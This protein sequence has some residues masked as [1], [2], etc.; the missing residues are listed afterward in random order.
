MGTLKKDFKYKKIKNFL[1]VDEAKFLRR[2]TIMYHQNNIDNFDF[3]QNK[4]A[5]TSCYSDFAMEPLMIGKK[6]LVEK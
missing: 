3:R 4:N 2:Y 1:T 6:E 5:D